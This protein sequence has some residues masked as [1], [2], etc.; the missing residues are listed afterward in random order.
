MRGP[1]SSRRA[2]LAGVAGSLPLSL[3]GCSALGS[4]RTLGHEVDVAAADG[5]HHTV[6]LRVLTADDAVLLDRT[7]D[8]APDDFASVE[9]AGDPSRV[10]VAVDGGAPERRAWPSPDCS[11]HTRSGLELFVTDEGLVYRGSC[12]TVA[13]TPD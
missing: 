4:E 6:D 11:Q 1:R 13:I 5:R 3:A 9:F 2:L 10:L 12:E 8:L 7:F